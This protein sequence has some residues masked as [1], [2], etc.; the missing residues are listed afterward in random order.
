MLLV[1]EEVSMSKMPL[2]L[3]LRKPR[4]GPKNMNGERDHIIDISAFTLQ[5]HHL[6]SRY[7][8]NDM[9]A[10]IYKLFLE[11][12]FVMIECWKLPI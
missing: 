11:A 10:Q 5:H 4:N 2:Q 12:L 7:S 9:K 8:S 3:K 6:T 1:T